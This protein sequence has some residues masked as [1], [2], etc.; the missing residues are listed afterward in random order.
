MKTDREE[1]AFRAVYDQLVD[2]APPAPSWEDLMDTST[3]TKK[4]PADRMPPSRRPVLIAAASALLVALFIGG[5]ALFGPLGGTEDVELIDEPAV[6][7]TLAPET[8]TTAATPE[9]SAPTTAAP[10]EP[11]EWETIIGPPLRFPAVEMAG[12]GY[13]MIVGRYGIDPNTG[14]G[15]LVLVRCVDPNCL[16]EPE[17]FD[18]IE[19]APHQ[20]SLQAVEGPE[21]YPV[22]GVNMGSDPTQTYVDPFTGFEWMALPF[23]EV[24]YCRDAG[25]SATDRYSVGS[26]TAFEALATGGWM[27]AAGGWMF[28]PEGLP[29]FVYAHGEPDDRAIHLVLCA[30]PGCQ[31]VKAEVV[32]DAARAAA[33]NP[34]NIGGPVPAPEV[35]LVYTVATPT[36]PPGLEGGWDEA[37]YYEE[38]RVATCA[39]H[40]CSEGP[41]IR[42]I[43][44]GWLVRSFEGP[45]GLPRI[46]VRTAYVETPVSS[47]EAST[48]RDTQLTNELVT[49]LDPSCDRIER[50]SLGTT[51][52]SGPITGYGRWDFG[53]DGAPIGVATF[54]IFEEAMVPGEYGMEPGYVSVGN[55]LSYSRCD[56][57]TCTSWTTTEL[58][59]WTEDN[60]PDG[61]YLWGEVAGVFVKPDGLPLVFFDGPD[62]IHLLHCRDLACTPPSD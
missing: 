15:T 8:P 55:R 47:P 6:T 21:G 26:Q 36:S 38:V 57:A 10:T 5:F 56:D 59:R 41:T 42:T 51:D 45:D 29:M 46:V 54:G 58:K 13:P 33:G 48:L 32:V 7:T 50:R 35:Q 27:Y 34:V 31:A 39:D 12:D 49:C 61:W 52:L 25:C 53:P 14:L 24:L 1:H 40:I 44:P 28:G 3:R 18:L 22:V 19:D 16:E 2:P 37:T 17:V 43:G 11:L 9:T 62:G 4:S 20:G 60:D 30:D 23:N